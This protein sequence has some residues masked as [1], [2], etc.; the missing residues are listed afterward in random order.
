MGV[1]L[2]RDSAPKS[3]GLFDRALGS[4]FRLT[5]G[6]TWVD[7]LVFIN[8]DDGAEGL[9]ESEIWIRGGWSLWG[10]EGEERRRAR[11]EN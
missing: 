4:M 2:F 3:F 9:G 5:A 10:V 8:P 1:A 11:G 6:E 7:E